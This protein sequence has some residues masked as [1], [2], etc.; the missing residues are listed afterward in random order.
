MC[1]YY[2]ISPTYLL[3]GIG[4]VHLSEIEETLQQSALIEKF[5]ALRDTADH[6][7]ARLAIAHEVLDNMKRTVELAPE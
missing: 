7:A 2:D 3:F 6:I 4:R 5:G 1:D